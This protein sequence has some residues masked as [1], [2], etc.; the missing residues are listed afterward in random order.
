MSDMHVFSLI[1]RDQYEFCKNMPQNAILFCFFYLIRPNNQKIYKKTCIF[2]NDLSDYACADSK[3][4]CAYQ[5]GASGPD[6]FDCSGFV[7]WVMKNCG[8]QTH[9]TAPSTG[10][11]KTTYDSK[12]AA[13]SIIPVYLFIYFDVNL[14]WSFSSQRSS[15]LR[16]M[17]PRIK[18]AMKMADM[19]ITDI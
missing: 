13:Y 12:Y 9:I 11:W 16:Y 15:F 6:K 2:I 7:Y 4:G 19:I 5:L 17:T 3:L 8:A 18:S 1:F 14:S 10:L